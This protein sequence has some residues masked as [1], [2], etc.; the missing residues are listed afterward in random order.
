MAFLIIMPEHK[1]DAWVRH[2][3]RLEPG[4]DL[5]IWPDT[6]PPEAIEFVLMWNHPPGA[7]SA[8]PN[9]KCIASMGAGVDHILR[10]ADLPSGI[11]VTRIVDPDMA[12]SMSA[13][14]VAAALNY[15]RQC[16]DYFHLQAS[17]K[18]APRIPRRAADTPVGIM[19]MG[20]LGRSAAAALRSAAFPVAGWR[21]SAGDVAGITVFHGDAGRV[22]FLEQTQILINL[23]P[24]TA[25]TRGILNGDT[26]SH[27]LPEAYIINAARGEH[28]VENDLLKAIDAGR[29]SGACLDVF[30]AEPLPPEHRFWRHPAITVTP[31]VA[32]LTNPK[33]V[34]PRI[35]ENYRR[36]MDGLP[37]HDQINREKGY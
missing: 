10:D 8:F 24:L 31:H 33:S 1:P 7:L 37:P 16:R 34:L 12:V 14:L 29:L 18:W 17:G 22:P 25:A 36:V 19:G 15:I 30:R 6:G 2:L 35:V 21:R 27:L 4:I 11:P 3:R 20:H 32:S 26:F 9:L 23:L 5:R 13:Y 28:L